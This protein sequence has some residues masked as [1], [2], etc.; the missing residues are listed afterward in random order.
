[1]EID[2]GISPALEEEE[3][4]LSIRF[5]G[6][7]GHIVSGAPGHFETF[8]RGIF[9]AFKNL[10]GE[11]KC[12]FLGSESS[13]E[14]NHWFIPSIPNSFTSTISWVPKD[15]L[16]SYFECPNSGDDNFLLYVYE[17]NLA[18]L[19]LLGSIARRRSNV[20]LYFN[21]FDSNKYQTALKSRT[22]LYVFKKL[23]SLALRGIQGKVFLTG[24][25]KRFAELLSSQL[26][27]NFSEYPIYSVLPLQSDTNSTRKKI[28]INFRGL[29]SEELF[30]SALEGF[31][32]LQNLELD[33]HG[34]HDKNVA[35]RLAKFTNLRFLP[36]QVDE[37]SYF[38]LYRDYYR[39]AFIYDPDFFSMQSSGRLADAIV[40]GAELVVPIGTSLEDALIEFGNGS[41][42]D[43]EKEASLAQALLSEPSIKRK[44]KQR[45]TSAW[46]ATTILDKMQTLIEKDDTPCVNRVS[47]LLNYAIDE[48]IRA[49]LW[50][51]RLLFGFWKRLHILL[52][53][54]R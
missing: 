30:Q 32:E 1:L 54:K 4:K 39:V 28:L 37:S 44:V 26:A 52:G 33:L 8:H 9:H 7:S 13:L 34:V 10:I 25:S 24:D 20:I 15:F 42:F 48:I 18:N 38:S 50:V 45:P 43:F 35:Q 5:V 49:A 2:R 46:A 40:A 21:L 12:I 19:F 51:L 16:Q 23:F 14:I 31:P 22:K 6:L 29:L 47:K 53:F 17:G 41:S 36:D 3:V 11:E 27:Q